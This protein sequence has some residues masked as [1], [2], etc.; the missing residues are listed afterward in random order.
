[1]STFRHVATVKKNQAEEVRICLTEYGEHKLV[2]VRVCTTTE[3]FGGTL[4]PSRKGF[5]L[6]RA[7][8]PALIAA[9]QKAEREG[10]AR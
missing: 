8:L 6:S 4:G 1:M 10:G 9:L 5:S 7:K 3:R 2:D